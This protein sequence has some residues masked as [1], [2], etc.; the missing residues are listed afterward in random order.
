MASEYGLCMY[1]LDNKNTEAYFVTR[2]YT[3]R[4]GNGYEP[5]FPIVI[6]DWK[7]ESN[8]DNQFQGKFKTV[9]K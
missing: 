9:S 2:T 3:T 8:I 4:H 6:P 5:K 7:K 1:Y